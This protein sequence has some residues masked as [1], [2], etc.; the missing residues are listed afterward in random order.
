MG[1]LETIG[2]AGVMFKAKYVKRTGSPGKYRYWYRNPKTGGLEAGKRPVAKRD[3]VDVSKYS[4]E[5]LRTVSV[6]TSSEKVRASAKKELQRREKV[7]GAIEKRESD[8]IQVA[9]RKLRKEFTENKEKVDKKKDKLSKDYVDERDAARD[10]YDKGYDES[11]QKFN[12]KI[13]DLEKQRNERF[14]DASDKYYAAMDKLD[15]KEA[16]RTLGLSK[17]YSYGFEK[18]DKK[19]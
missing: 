9:N 10:G 18:S 1:P 19:K 7:E 8:R 12:K 4:N 16:K 14:N 11:Y 17:E 3:K 15:A 5:S 6:M 2:A 13:K